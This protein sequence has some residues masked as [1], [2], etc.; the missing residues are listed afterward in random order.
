MI[1]FDK[2]VSKLS[3]KRSP[4][5]LM[6]D[7]VELIDPENARA[8]EGRREIYK[9]AYKLRAQGVVL[10]LRNG[11]FLIK[12]ADT[13]MRQGESSERYGIRMVDEFYWHIARSYIRREVGS[14][15]CI[16]GDKALELHLADQSIPST[17]IVYTKY[18]NKKI[19]LSGSHVL[20]FKS[21]ETS[22]DK[23][24]NFLTSMQPFITKKDVGVAGKESGI[25][26][27]E[28]KI[29][30][31]EAALLDA[32]LLHN[33]QEGI[34]RYLLDRFLAKFNR[35]LRRDELG[36][37]VELRYISAINRLREMARDGKYEELYRTCISII[38][39][40]GAGCFLTMTTSR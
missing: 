34:D 38:R 6:D 26:P 40:E 14:E 25:L 39:D 17:L 15:Y 10:S 24:R 7:L 32:L 28:L 16:G 36:R 30:D 18:T 8:E 3:A 11:L 2:I 20:V 23:K 4:V 35:I 27:V 1:S 9:M 29:L 12:R 33:R 5:V 13:A 21:R 37:L 19:R 31:L 22:E